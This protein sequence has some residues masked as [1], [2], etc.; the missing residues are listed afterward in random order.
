MKALKYEKGEAFFSLIGAI[1]EELYHS[2]YTLNLYHHAFQKLYNEGWRYEFSRP[3]TDE[4][5]RL[6]LKFEGEI[7]EEDKFRDQKLWLVR[8][9]LEKFL[10]IIRKLKSAGKL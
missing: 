1:D 8:V 3:T 7:L 6:P 9:K 10:L 2:G 4:A 5:L